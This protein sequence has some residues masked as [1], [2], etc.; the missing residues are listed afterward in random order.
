MSVNEIDDLSECGMN[1]EGERGLN[2]NP[3]INEC[4]DMKV[5]RL[6]E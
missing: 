1:D 5:M 6:M 4:D 3:I 2:E